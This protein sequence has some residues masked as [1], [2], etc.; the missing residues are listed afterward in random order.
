MLFSV[1]H[2]KALLLSLHILYII[3]YIESQLFKWW[4]NKQ[5]VC[6]SEGGPFI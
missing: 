2:E 3:L 5:N 4:N 1:T 6:L